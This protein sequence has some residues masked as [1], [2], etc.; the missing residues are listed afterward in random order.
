MSIL[1]DAILVVCLA[2]MGIFLLAWVVLALMNRDIESWENEEPSTRRSLRHVGC[3][4]GPLVALMSAFLLC[5]TVLQLVSGEAPAFAAPASLVYAAFLW[6]S[7]RLSVWAWRNTSLSELNLNVRSSDNIAQAVA[8]GASVLLGG[9]AGM[10]LSDDGTAGLLVGCFAGLVL[11]LLL[12][13]VGLMVY[14]LINP[15]PDDPKQDEPENPLNGM[16]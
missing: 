13:G 3:C 8:I 5:A 4:N 2:I 7:L 15:I 6:V 12:S 11:G 14:R 16:R 9:L 1:D 10:L